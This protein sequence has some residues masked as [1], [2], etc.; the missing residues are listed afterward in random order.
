MTTD[1]RTAQEKMDAGLSELRSAYYSHVRDTARE[2]VEECRSGEIADREALI[3]R[4][5]QECDG[6]EWV[7]Y[8]QKAQVVLLV[9]EN[10]SAGIDDLGADGFDWSAGVPWSQLAYFALRQDLY[11][12]LEAEGLDVNDDS[13]WQSDEDV[14]E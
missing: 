7:I 1:T 13:D 9:S 11:E 14:D 4:I 8:T 2:L 3:E 12:Q 5:D 6:T 10:D